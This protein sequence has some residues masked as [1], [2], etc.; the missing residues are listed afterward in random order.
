M[1]VAQEQGS[2]KRRKRRWFQFGLR[3][4]FL[5]TTALAVWLGI[6][7]HRARQQRDAVAAIRRYGG[8]VRYDYHFPSGA[9]TY[10]DYDGNAESPFPSWLVDYLGIDFLHSVVQVNLNFSE[11]SGARQENRNRTDEALRYLPQ[12]PNLRVLLLEGTQA[13]DE[14]LR[15]LAGLRKLERLYMWDVTEVS[16][17][18]AAHLSG[19]RNLR[20]I[21][22][23]NSK[24]TDVSLKRFAKLP[25]L[26]ELSLQFNHFT[27][28]G[29]EHVAQRTALQSLWVCGR[30]DRE[31]PITDAGLEHLKALKHLQSLGIQNTRV[32]DEGV[33]DFAK[34]VPQCRII[35]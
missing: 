19:L 11:D 16:D 20:L 4:L 26:E 34:A 23:S 27:D 29:L 22:L 25:K 32:T 31:N 1:S 8:W 14:S 7:T 17:A 30:L 21:H 15:Y 5:V 10:K 12:L 13:R 9:Y 6:H 28:E 18:G 3:T 24:I 33:A 2:I 35:R